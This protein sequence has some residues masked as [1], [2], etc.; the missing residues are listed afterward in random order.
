MK[1]KPFRY[2]PSLGEWSIMNMRKV[3][4]IIENFN[5]SILKWRELI[6]DALSDWS[7][8]AEPYR[9]DCKYCSHRKVCLSC[10]GFQYTVE[11]DKKL[12]YGGIP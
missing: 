5:K 11:N 2:D 4:E 6:K 7:T 8:T 10:L 9:N 12:V 1:D 3:Y